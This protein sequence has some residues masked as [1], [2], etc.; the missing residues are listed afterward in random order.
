[1]TFVIKVTSP[2]SHPRKYAR[3]G[4]QGRRHILL[5]H[6]EKA[7]DWLDDI[8]CSCYNLNLLKDFNRIYWCKVIQS[9]SCMP[10]KWTFEETTIY[11]KILSDVQLGIACGLWSILRY[12][13]FKKQESSHIGIPGMTRK[14]SLN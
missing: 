3:M 14:P 7:W 12:V 4:C 6:N 11:C 9:F 8:D 5:L 13:E 2:S 1:M 10:E